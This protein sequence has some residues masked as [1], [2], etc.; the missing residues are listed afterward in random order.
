MAALFFMWVGLKLRAQIQGRGVLD[1]GGHAGMVVVDL[2]LAHAVKAHDC[3]AARLAG[4]PG[5]GLRVVGIS[6][7]GEGR[8]ALGHLHGE[9]LRARLVEDGAMHWLK[10]RA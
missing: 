2:F 10:V 9:A 7:V 8:I 3:L 1:V 6:G 5:R 4:M